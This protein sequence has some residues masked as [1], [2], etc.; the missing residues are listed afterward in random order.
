MIMITT[1]MVMVMIVIITIIF[2]IND[3][4]NERKLSMNSPHV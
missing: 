2:M 3:E 1:M 4:C